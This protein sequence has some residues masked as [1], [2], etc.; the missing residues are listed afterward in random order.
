M[1]SRLNLAVPHHPVTLC[2]LCGFGRFLT[3]TQEAVTICSQI[4]NFTL[5]LLNAIWKTCNS[6]RP[7]KRVFLALFH[8][9]QTVISYENMHRKHQ[10]FHNISSKKTAY[11]VYA[12]FCNGSPGWVIKKRNHFKFPFIQT[13]FWLLLLDTRRQF[14]QSFNAGEKFLC[15]YQSDSV[16]LKKKP[17]SNMHLT[18]LWCGN[19]KPLI[20]VMALE[21]IREQAMSSVV[22]YVTSRGR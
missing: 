2:F 14:L 15:T 5:W 7:E 1:K 6:V 11:I 21:G 12:H 18:Q 9:R 3:F 20:F 4:N 19:W 16:S 8:K 13:V 10:H 17:G 22:T